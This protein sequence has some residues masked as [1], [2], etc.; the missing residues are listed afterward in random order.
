LAAEHGLRIIEDCAQAQGASYKRRPMGSLGDIVIFSFCQDKIMTTGGEGG[1]LVTDDESFFRRA[2][3]FKDHGKSYEA[4]NERNHAAGFRWLHESIGTNWRMTEMQSAMG[5]V[6]LPKVAQRV[7][8]RRENASLLQRGL[9]EITAL[10][11]PQPPPGLD[12]AFYRFYAYV[13]PERLATGW[14]HDRVQTA[15]EAEG[16]P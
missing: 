2:W 3:S 6:M 5:R 4:I 13:R 14:D 7:K 15:I 16:I 10:R 11:V 12:C 1:M 9:S 8:Q